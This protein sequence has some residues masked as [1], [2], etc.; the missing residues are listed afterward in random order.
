MPYC[1]PAGYYFVGKVCPL[2]QLHG[3]SNI[4]RYLCLGLFGLGFQLVGSYTFCFGERDFESLEALY[5]YVYM[6]ACMYVCL[7]RC[8]K[9]VKGRW[10]GGGMDKGKESMFALISVCIV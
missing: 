9:I 2:R 1:I 4:T 3:F 8:E 5:M 6:H 7:N 10:N